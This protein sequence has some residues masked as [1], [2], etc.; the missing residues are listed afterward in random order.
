MYD[1]RNNPGDYDGIN[2]WSA[3][4]EVQTYLHK[5]KGS[6]S[7]CWES[8]EC[9][10]AALGSECF[11]AVMYAMNTGI[12]ENPKWYPGL[13]E[14]STFA[15]FQ[16]HLRR[17]LSNTT[18]CQRPCR[19]GWKAGSSIFCWSVARNWGY[20]ADVIKG[21]VGAGA[22]IFACDG[23]AVVSEHDW[24][25]GWGPGGRIG[26]VQAITF[27]GAD[28][29]ISKDFTAANTQLFMNAWQA[30]MEKT[31]ILRYDWAIKVDPDAVVVADRLRDRLGQ[32]TGQ[33]VYVR[34]CNAHPES[35]DFPMM[36][37]SLEALSRQALL[38]YRDNQGRCQNELDWHSW[39]EDY[40]LG[41]CLQHIGVRAVDDM[42][43][44]SDGVC[45]YVN[46]GDPSSAAFHPFKDWN[47][48]NWCW[49][50]VTAGL[51]GPSLP[52]P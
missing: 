17:T 37:G 20:E 12:Y 44:I 19:D 28:V 5:H 23:F 43:M 7:Q 38:A 47:S 50:I 45:S 33:N 8:C 51:G 3:F 41:K 39:G 27:Q 6:K 29:G 40:F 15:D 4:E 2:K 48:W 49:S 16:N 14:W 52:L 13:D 42:G 18:G 11:G 22:G 10:T 32:W 21:Q 1:L 35:P 26:H 46:C 25:V 34:N 24:E 30:V 36:Y 31:L 9:E